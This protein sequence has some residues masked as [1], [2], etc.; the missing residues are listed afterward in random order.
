[1]SS[2]ERENVP[3]TQKNGAPLEATQEIPVLN[4][5][6]IKVSS[7]AASKAFYSD[8]FGMKEIFAVNTGRFTAHYLASPSTPEETSDDMFASLSTRSGFLELIHE[9]SQGEGCEAGIQSGSNPATRSNPSGFVHLGYRVSDVAE[10]L[11]R[12]R[13]GGWTVLKDLNN[14]EVSQDVLP[15][16]PNSDLEATKFSPDFL[17]VLAQIGFVADPDG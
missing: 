5:L 17:P 4:H 9:E 3:K 14:T 2:T 6:A 10:T 1:M 8:V 16:R 15:G 13:R 7:L 12:A 11:A